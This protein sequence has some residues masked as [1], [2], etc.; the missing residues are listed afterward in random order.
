MFVE[1]RLNK[2]SVMYIVVNMSMVEL[3]ESCV[4]RALAL[5]SITMYK[6]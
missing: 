5:Y 3:E 4:F 1:T 2:L 6:I